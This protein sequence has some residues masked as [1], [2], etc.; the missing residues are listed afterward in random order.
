MANL[1]ELVDQLASSQYEPEEHLLAVT[2]VTR[3]QSMKSQ[4]AFG[5]AGGMIASAIA[6]KVESKHDHAATAT[7]FPGMPSMTFGLTDRRVVVLR[8]S[9]LS[10]QPQEIV[11]FINLAD[12]ASARFE[13]GKLASKLFVTMSDGTEEKFQAIRGDH[14]DA[15]AE[16]L[17][18][19]VSTN[20]R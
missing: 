5:M 2:R 1:A 4:A 18:Q 11:V 14:T 16:A 6:A 15:F 3:R 20:A 9:S 10:N 12:I 8:N 7:Q 17:M 13:K 19:S